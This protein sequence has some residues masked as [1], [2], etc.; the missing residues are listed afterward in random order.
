MRDINMDISSVYF[1]CPWFATRLLLM[2]QS[3][4]ARAA[5]CVSGISY[6]WISMKHIFHP[7]N[8]SLFDAF[9]WMVRSRAIHFHLAPLTNKSFRSLR[10]L[11]NKTAVAAENPW[12]KLSFIYKYLA[13]CNLEDFRHPLLSLFSKVFFFG[14]I[15]ILNFQ[16]RSAWQMKKK[17]RGEKVSS[18]R[19]M[20]IDS[21]QNDPKESNATAPTERAVLKK[22]I[23]I[24]WLHPGVGQLIN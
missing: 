17:Y 18:I 12:K 22:F 5:E 10:T 16:L 11:E 19:K 13:L 9:Y 2:K 15:W 21:R 20:T 24:D 8:W 3:S 6:L 14:K 23:F 7:L 4:L 1:W